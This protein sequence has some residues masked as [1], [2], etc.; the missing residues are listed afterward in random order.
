[1]KKLIALIGILV[2]CFSFIQVPVFAK[3]PPKDP[4]DLP[5]EID[6]TVV[7]VDHGYIYIYGDNFGET[8]AVVLNNTPLS[9]TQNLIREQR[10]SMYSRTTNDSF[11]DGFDQ[12]FK[13]LEDKIRKLK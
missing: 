10:E 8:P 5:L 1:M 11:R 12:K 9:V 4:E 3:R 7:D 13:E 6:S 2:F